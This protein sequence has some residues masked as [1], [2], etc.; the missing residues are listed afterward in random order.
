MGIS[1]FSNSS[2]ANGF[3]KYSKVKGD[4]KVGLLGPW[5]TITGFSTAR[6]RPIPIIWNSNIYYLYG[7]TGGAT[8]NTVVNYGTGN[9]TWTNLTNLP[10]QGLGGFVNADGSRVDFSGGYGGTTGHY[11]TTDF[12][13][14]TS[15]A[16]MPISGLR[17]MTSVMMNSKIYT[18]GGYTDVAGIAGYK[19]NTYSYNPSND[20]WTAETTF[21]KDVDTAA[22]FTLDGTKIYTCDYQNYSYTGSGS[23]TAETN[24]PYDTTGLFNNTT[25]YNKRA[26]FR[27]YATTYSY[28][29]G[30]WRL[31]TFGR[32][33]GAFGGAIL[34][35][36]YYTS[37]DGTS[38]KIQKSTIG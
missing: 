33:N 17:S 28:D 11:S 2:I 3:P 18:T 12:S 10:V 36:V 23:W 32:D 8:T 35:G 31:E 26:Y 38:A 22:S 29:G 27:L 7:D 6:S 9:G 1:K 37:P 13:T 16:A 14:Y 30:S 4:I 19:R 24:P 25:V 5:T 15:R 20:T 34:N 21:P